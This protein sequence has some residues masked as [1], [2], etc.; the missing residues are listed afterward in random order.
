MQIKKLNITVILLLLMIPLPMHK[1]N[2]R[3][4]LIAN[5]LRLAHVRKINGGDA[6]KVENGTLHFDQQQRKQSR[7]DLVT[8][9][10]YSNFHLKLD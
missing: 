10:E 8:D 1:M 9:K 7:G 2:S 5:P 6:W 4:F 3:V